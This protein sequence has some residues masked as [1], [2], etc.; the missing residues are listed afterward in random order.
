MNN[1]LKNNVAFAGGEFAM[2]SGGKCNRVF[3]PGT[4][5]VGQPTFTVQNVRWDFGGGAETGTRGACAPRIARFHT[6]WLA[7]ADAIHDCA[8]VFR[9]CAAATAHHVQP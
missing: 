2:I 9:G 5:E 6:A 1:A 3:P 8:D 4:L 7:V